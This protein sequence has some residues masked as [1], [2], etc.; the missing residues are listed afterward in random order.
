MFES[1]IV[2]DIITQYPEYSEGL[3]AQFNAARVIKRTINTF[4]FYT[5]YEVADIS[6]AIGGEN[7]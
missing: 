5:E 2:R 4:G 1:L 3:T 7:L 6:C